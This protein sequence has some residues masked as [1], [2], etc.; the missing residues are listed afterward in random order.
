MKK[1]ELIPQQVFNFIGYRFD[2]LTGRALPTPEMLECHSGQAVQTKPSDPDRV[3]PI[4]AGVQSLV[5][6]MGPTTSGPICSPVQSQAPSVCF[7]GTGSDSLGSRHAESAMRESGCVCLSSSFP[8]QPDRSRLSQNDPDCSRVAQHALVLGPSHS[9][10]PDSL[11]APPAK[12]SSDTA[13]QRVASQESQQSESACWLLEP[14]P[15]GNKGS[16]TKWQ[17]ELRLLKD[18]QSEPFTNQSGPFLC[19]H[20]AAWAYAST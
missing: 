12:G 14:L 9:I 8:S 1:L 17:Q 16:L 18:S 6:Q 19:H 20:S 13:L 11:Q 15:F 7:T 10:G 2:I 5:L 4:S 3:V